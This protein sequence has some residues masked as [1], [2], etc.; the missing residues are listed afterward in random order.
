MAKLIIH[1]YTQD[2]NNLRVPTYQ[3]LLKTVSDSLGGYVGWIDVVDT[4]NKT[5]FEHEDKFGFGKE[6]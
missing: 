2:E 4:T 6:E 1:A 3:E 5:T